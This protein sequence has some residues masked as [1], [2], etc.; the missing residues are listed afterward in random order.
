MLRP[1]HDDW[2]YCR[3]VLQ[4][5][6]RT[7]ALNIEHLE[8]DT[9]RAVLLGYLLFRIA[10]TFEDNTFRD[11]RD[12]ITD[13]TDFSDIFTGNRALPER[14]SLYEPLKN[15]W[16]D[17]SPEKGL[18]ENGHVVLQCYF[19]L[20]ALYRE[21]IDPLLS[22]S[23]GGMIWFQRRKMECKEE[24]FQ[25]KDIGELEEYCYYV[26]GIVGIMLT[27]IFCLKDRIGDYRAGLEKYQ[28]PFG[29]ALQMINIIKDYN[30]DMLRGW[31]YLPVSVTERCGVDIRDIWRLSDE[32]RKGIIRELTLPVTGHLDSTLSY[33]K[34]LPV[35]ERAVRMFCVIPFVLAYNTLHKIIRGEGNKLTRSE[36][37]SLLELCDVLAGSN[38]SLADDYMRVRKGL[39]GL[40]QSPQQV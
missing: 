37:R 29:L 11:E 9:Y 25:L 38:T 34:L 4:E 12:K 19:D 31:C 20:P 24:V 8:G 10:D 22:E 7:F 5:V 14:L 27:R 18:I 2:G 39:L 17:N 1:D 6:S 26:A 16:M 15:R 36:V 30:K 40:V 28:V 32:Q 13:L 35:E 21:I 23:I 3:R 33:I